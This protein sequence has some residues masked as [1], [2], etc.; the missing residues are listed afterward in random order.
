MSTKF[1]TAASTAVTFSAL[2][3][4]AIYAPARPA[5][6]A[7][8][9]VTSHVA[10]QSL[11]PEAVIAQAEA[12]G[13]TQAYPL[14]PM[15]SP[16]PA[17]QVEATDTDAAS[18]SEPRAR[19]LAA[20]VQ[21][22]AATQTANREMECLAGTVYFESKS[23]PLEGQLAVAETVINRSRSGRFPGSICGVVYQPSQFS[24]I[25]GGGMPPIA[26][27]GQQWKTAVAIA[28]IA[29]NDL[30]TSSAS[31]ALFFHA[32]RVS[33]GWKLRRVASVG[34]HVFYR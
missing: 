25:R 13:E 14:P 9:L 32:R 3:I 31:N 33:P 12:E 16:R 30:W 11:L 6:A 17:P 21:R 24:F 2:G 10:R 18:T 26:R 28:H 19:S 29:K 1:W 4:L 20:L 7:E 5:L 34:N 8:T 27:G 22:H 15:P 23:E